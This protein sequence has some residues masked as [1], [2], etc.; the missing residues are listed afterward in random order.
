MSKMIVKAQRSVIGQNTVLIYNKD[1][2]VVGELPCEGAIATA[3]GD[4][5]KAYFKAW[6]DSEGILHLHGE[7]A[8]K[9]W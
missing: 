9:N 3:L 1:R 7:V 6:I 4:R 2:S 5:D 8:N